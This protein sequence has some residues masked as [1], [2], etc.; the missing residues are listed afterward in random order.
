M[1]VLRELVSVKR[2]ILAPCALVLMTLIAA[3]LLLFAPMYFLG[4]QAEESRQF[5]KEDRPPNAPEA[6]MVVPMNY[7]LESNDAN[8][9][10]FLG[11]SAC[12]VGIDPKLFGEVAGLSAWNL[13]GQF[14]LGIDGMELI[15]RAYLDHHPAPRAVVFCVNPRVL[16]LSTTEFVSPWREMHARFMRC[17]GSSLSDAEPPTQRSVQYLAGEGVRIAYRRATKGKEYY[18]D[19]SI[20]G[21]A[22]TYRD[23][24]RATLQGRG[25][26][27]LDNA[28]KDSAADSAKVPVGPC[29]V[30]ASWRAGLRA[31][32]R[33][34]QERDIALLVR[35]APV[36][37]A[38]PLEDSAELTET[39]SELESTYSNTHVSRPAII[40]YDDRLLHDDVH[41]NADGSTQ[42]TTLVA[43]EVQRV[44]HARATESRVPR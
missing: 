14:S 31:L 10:V 27:A 5:L 17:Y 42:F 36:S 33:R 22:G 21:G 37:A 8:D 26:A 11:D 19:A 30:A 20:P 2:G 32:V 34:L 24:Q 44:L 15:I 13:G 35:L 6:E 4:M 38:H 16:G 7:A 23:Y 9:V 41:L 3:I 18:V 29:V 1:K 12:R 28:V 25:F 40:V 43:E 39:L